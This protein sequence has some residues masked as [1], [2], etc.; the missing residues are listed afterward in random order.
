MTL[1]QCGEACT[2]ST[3][4]CSFEWSPSREVCGFNKGCIPTHVQYKDNIF[5][6]PNDK[7]KITHVKYC[8]KVRYLLFQ[9]L[10]ISPLVLLVARIR[11]R[12]LQERMFS[13]TVLRRRKRS[14]GKL[15]LVRLGLGQ[16]W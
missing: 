10:V 15:L 9:P 16:N 7:S 2:N 5:C 8:Y 1:E 4:C 13:R 6:I 12:L 11:G 14:I 3:E